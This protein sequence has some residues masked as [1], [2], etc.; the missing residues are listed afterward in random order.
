M[1]DLDVGVDRLKRDLKGLEETLNFLTEP[2]FK[3][4]FEGVGHLLATIFIRSAEMFHQ[5]NQTG[6]KKM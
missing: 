1:N 5:I 6:I 3:Y 4:V 2:K